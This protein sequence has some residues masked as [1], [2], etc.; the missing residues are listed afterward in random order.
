MAPT[1]STGITNMVTRMR[2]AAHS[3]VK[4]VAENSNQANKNKRKAD[5]VLSS[6][7]KKRSALGDLTNV[8]SLSP[9]SFDLFLSNCIYLINKLLLIVQI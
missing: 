2:S 8:S 4:A 6:T 9:Y 5:T 3:T 1:K 7:N